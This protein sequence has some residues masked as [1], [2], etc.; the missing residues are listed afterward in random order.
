MSKDKTLI[1]LI[2]EEPPIGVWC[3]G[4][5]GASFKVVDRGD[6]YL[7]ASDINKPSGEKRCIVKSFVSII[8]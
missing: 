5:K 6:W 8:E 3:F 7:L 2:I 1:V 4:K